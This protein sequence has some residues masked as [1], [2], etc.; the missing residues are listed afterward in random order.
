MKADVK[1][2]NWLLRS[3]HHVRHFV[4]MKWVPVPTTEIVGLVNAMGD[5][6]DSQYIFESWCACTATCI[7]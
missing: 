2:G 6:E 7:I 5:G 4:D 3:N 1:H